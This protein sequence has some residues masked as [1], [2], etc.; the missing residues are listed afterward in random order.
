MIELT[1]KLVY[2]LHFMVEIETRTS[3]KLQPLEMIYDTGSGTTTI[4]RKLALDAGYAI[5]PLPLGEK[6]AVITGVIDS[7]DAGYTII[8]DLVLNGVHFGPVYAHV[9]RFD[10]ALAQ[11]TNAILGMNV[12]SWFRVTQEC[13]WNEGLCRFDRAK[14]LFEPKYDINDIQS[15][16]SFKPLERGQRFG[17]VFAAVGE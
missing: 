13:F 10:A 5:K 17:T 6:I 2:T 4:D 8:P 7:K 12:I 15:L 14:L 9:V 16:D 3:Q 11:R 1:A